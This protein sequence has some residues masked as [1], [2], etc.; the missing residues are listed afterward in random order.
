MS[1][2][3]RK[4]AYQADKREGIPGRE[5]SKKK[6]A[7]IS[8]I[9]KSGRSLT[10]SDLTFTLWAVLVLQDTRTERRDTKAIGRK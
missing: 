3:T 6:E 5:N 1:R 9:I 4:T 7:R 10:I 8:G 2:I